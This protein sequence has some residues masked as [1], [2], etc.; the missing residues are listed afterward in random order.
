MLAS[1][2]IRNGS[3]ETSPRRHEGHEGHEG[4]VKISILVFVRKTTKPQQE[5][6]SG[7]RVIK[8]KKVAVV[9]LRDLRVLR[10]FV[11]K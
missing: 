1:T 4:P 10:A 3:G 8:N 6:K 11:V 5:Y 2:F 9:V 7:L